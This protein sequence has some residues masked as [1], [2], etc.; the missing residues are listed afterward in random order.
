M[1][2]DR[3]WYRQVTTGYVVKWDDDY[4][5]MACDGTQSPGRFWDENKKGAVKLPRATAFAVARWLRANHNP[6]SARVLRRYKVIP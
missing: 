1:A 3:P 5:M 6:G 4:L 2:A